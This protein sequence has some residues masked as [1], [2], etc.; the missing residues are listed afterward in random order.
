MHFP[1]LLLNSRAGYLG[2]RRVPVIG[3]ACRTG[4]GGPRPGDEPE[5]AVPHT[6]RPGA[7]PV[8]PVPDLERPVQEGAQ[9]PRRFSVRLL[10]VGRSQRRPE[11]LRVRL[12]LGRLQD[13]EEEP[14]QGRYM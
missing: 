5:P 9:E 4:G 10:R 8:L 2:L 7:E 13:L 6:D 3:E 11:A 12:G 14:V 1:L